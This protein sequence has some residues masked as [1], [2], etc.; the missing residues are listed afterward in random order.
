MIFPASSDQALNSF[1][2]ENGNKVLP[3][4]ARCRFGRL[5]VNGNVKSTNF[6][7]DGPKKLRNGTDKFISDHFGVSVTLE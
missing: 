1:T 4:K 3:F 5:Y 7:L 2:G 6:K